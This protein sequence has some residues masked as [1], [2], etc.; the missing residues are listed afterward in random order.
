MYITEYQSTGARNSIEKNYILLV[1]VFSVCR[2]TFP[3]WQDDRSSDNCKG[4]HYYT[5]IGLSHLVTGRDLNQSADYCTSPGISQLITV[6]GVYRMGPGIPSSWSVQ[7][8]GPCNQSADSFTGPDI[9]GPVKDK[10]FSELSADCCTNMSPGI[11]PLGSGIRS[12]FSQIFERQS[13]DH[14]T[15]PGNQSADKCMHGPWHYSA[16]YQPTDR[17][18]P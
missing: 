9:K 14:F 13:A 18:C 2:A 7:V 3:T 8:C 4:G 5:G 10:A 1:R 6:R 11:S 17:P 12:A 15:G 16:G